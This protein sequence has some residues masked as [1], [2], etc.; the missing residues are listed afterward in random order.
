MSDGL[1]NISFEQALDS[2]QLLLGCGRQCG[3]CHSEVK[4]CAKQSWQDALSYSG[5]EDQQSVAEDVA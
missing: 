3:S 4:Q 5:I 1:A 2:T